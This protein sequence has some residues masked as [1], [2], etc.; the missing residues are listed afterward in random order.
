MN[1]KLEI[2]ANSINS[3]RAAAQGGADRIEL[4]DNLHEG[5]T[6]PSAA[7]IT[8]CKE[9]LAL[10]V[11]PL[12]RPRGGNFVYNDAEFNCLLMDIEFC[13]SANCNGIVTGVLLPDD[14]LDIRKCKE[15]IKKADGM[16]VAFHR[17]FDCCTQPAKVLE[18]LIDLGFVRILSSGGKSNALLGAQQLAQYQA[19]AK[20]R[21]E[22]MPGAG[23]QPENISQIAQITGAHNFHA[24]AKIPISN[25][26]DEQ[27]PTMGTAAS[28]TYRYE[29]SAA[30]V[31]QLRQQLNRFFKAKN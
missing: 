9:Q 3:A 31:Q 19:Q 4:C 17:A 22:I 5:G 23:I 2:C 1:F 8:W 24:T 26:L 13:K 11:W 20:E 6:T 16:S 21:I 28:D 15:I 18:Q 25:C 30:I 7:Q 12:I 10:E 27:Q 29:S 14:N